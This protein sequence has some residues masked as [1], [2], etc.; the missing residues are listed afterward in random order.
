MYIRDM[1]IARRMT[2]GRPPRGVVLLLS[3]LLVSL[4]AAQDGYGLRLCPHHDAAPGAQQHHDH[5]HASHAV[6]ADGSDP[7]PGEQPG[8][9][10]CIGACVTAADLPLDTPEVL[11]AP[12]Q[13][14]AQLHARCSDARFF[15]A[16]LPHVLPYSQ[17]PPT[18]G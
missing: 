2:L 17:A 5:H 9:C 8:G 13:S 12:L 16:L 18:A 3:L 4:G 15:P 7:A 1:S 6:G 11:A 14:F 10:S